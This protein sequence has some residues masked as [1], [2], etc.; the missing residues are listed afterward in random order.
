M[1]L[2]AIF[3]KYNVTTNQDSDPKKFRIL[4]LSTSD[5]KVCKTFNE[6]K[7]T[8]INKYKQTTREY[9]ERKSGFEKL[10]ER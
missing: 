1:N 4:E 3:E 10:K 9:Q 8:T 5:C 6:I 7:Y 2:V